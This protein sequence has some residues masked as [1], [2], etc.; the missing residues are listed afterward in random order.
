MKIVKYSK[1]YKNVLKLQKNY[2]IDNVNNLKNE[3]KINNKYI[4]QKKRKNCK[5][6]QKILA[7]PT[8]KS[9]GV[10]YS[11]CKTCGHLNGINE[12]TKNFTQQLYINDKGSHYDKEYS[13]DFNNR[14][15]NIYLPKVKFLKQVI[16]KKLNLLDIGS[17]AGHF[18][19]A[20]ESVKISAKGYEIS[21][22]LVDF[23]KKKL[24]KNSIE[25]VSIDEMF[26]ILENENKA[27]VVSLIGV[28]EHFYNPEKFLKSF[29]KSKVD[30]LYLAVPLFSFSTFL[31]NAFPKVYPRQLS[32]DHTHLYT[33]KSLLYLAKKN[34]LKIIGEWWFGADIPDLCRSLIVSS[35]HLDK[36]SY[37]KEFNKKLYSVMDSLQNVL[38]QNKICSEVHMI[39]K[40]QK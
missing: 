17:G 30:Y 24:K 6:C 3:L 12:N 28:L 31:E 36:K 22:Y 26:K 13:N 7:K 16:N 2:L 1:T 27:N 29:K 33:E 5:N 35:N 8:F 19:K 32:G 18:L 15:K 38:D 40:K 4:K 39:F 20:C 23:A 11:V 34:N 14:V 25:K 9:F 10:K 21:K 37:M